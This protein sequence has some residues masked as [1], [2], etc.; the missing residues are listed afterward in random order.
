M[1]ELDAALADA[2]LARVRFYE[3]FGLDV[4]DDAKRLQDLFHVE[5]RLREE[6]ERCATS[7]SG[8]A[9]SAPARPTS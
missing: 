7:R 2:R 1:T 9:S 8:N 5:R 6:A 4:S 3:S